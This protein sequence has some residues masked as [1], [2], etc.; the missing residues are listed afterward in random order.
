MAALFGCLYIVAAAAMAVTDV[1][2]LN[3]CIYDLKP[4]STTQLSILAGLRCNQLNWLLDCF[5]LLLGCM[6]LL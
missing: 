5:Q 2:I 1:V 4:K 6:Q 3:V